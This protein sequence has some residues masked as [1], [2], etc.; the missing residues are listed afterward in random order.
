MTRGWITGSGGIPRVPILVVLDR[1]YISSSHFNGV[2]VLIA[3]SGSRSSI[4]VY[5]P[6]SFPSAPPIQVFQNSAHFH[7]VSPACHQSI[8]SRIQFISYRFHQHHE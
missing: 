8:T 6:A 4:T 3:R 2:K 7:P 1:I 5:F